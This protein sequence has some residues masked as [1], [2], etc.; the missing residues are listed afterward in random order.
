MSDINRSTNTHQTRRADSVSG[1]AGQEAGELRTFLIDEN[2]GLLKQG[3]EVIA[4][5]SA[6]EYSR[7]LEGTRAAGTVGKH[8][9]HVLNFYQNLCEHTEGVLNYDT[10]IRDPDVENRPESAL[11]LLGDIESMLNEWRNPGGSREQSIVI[12]IGNGSESMHRMESSLE[13]ELKFV[14]EHSLHHYAIISMVLNSR[15]IPV[16]PEF[17]I[18]P[19]TLAF[20]GRR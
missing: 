7:P 10:R 16:P 11:K 19:S 3:R 12:A 4:S 18:A 15:N 1:S 13:R 6:G 2:L 8:F 14:L 5:L 17:G 20:L 9:R